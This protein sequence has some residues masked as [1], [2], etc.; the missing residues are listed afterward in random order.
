MKKRPGVARCDLKGNAV[1]VGS[2]RLLNGAHVG[3]RKAQQLL[4]FQAGHFALDDRLIVFVLPEHGRADVP[5][6]LDAKWRAALELGRPLRRVFRLGQ[7][8]PYF[9]WECIDLD[10]LINE[11]F[12][13]AT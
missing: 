8:I 5:V 3:D 12:R 6:G 9:K 4:G 1:L 2:R 11:Q 13:H 7:H 10:R